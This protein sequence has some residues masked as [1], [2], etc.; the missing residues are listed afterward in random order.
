MGRPAPN[1]L[2]ATA[3]QPRRRR[4]EAE[5][6]PV[7]WI[8]FGSTLSQIDSFAGVVSNWSYFILYFYLFIFQMLAI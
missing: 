4:T 3:R 1:D 6:E 5:V 8:R 7:G 2:V